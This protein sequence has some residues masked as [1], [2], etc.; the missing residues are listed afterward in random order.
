[1]GYAKTLLRKFEEVQVCQ[2][3]LK[4]KYQ[5]SAIFAFLYKYTGVSSEEGGEAGDRVGDGRC[6]GGHCR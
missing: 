5:G 4:F 3:I 6:Q 1:M 2:Y